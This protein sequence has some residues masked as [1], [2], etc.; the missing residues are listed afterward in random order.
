MSTIEATSTTVKV[1]A[2]LLARAVSNATLFA[3]KD[4]MRPVLTMAHLF[5]DNGK[6]CVETTDSYVAYRETVAETEAPEGFSVL[7]EVAELAPIVKA[8]KAFAAGMVSMETDGQSV[9]FDVYSSSFTVRDTTTLFDFPRTDTFFDQ[10]TVGTE[11]IAHIG[12]GAQ[13]L[14]RLA[15]VDPDGRKSAAKTGH[16]LKI[17]VQNELKPARVSWPMNDG[18]RAVVMPVRIS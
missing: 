6:V 11:P 17:E 18:I 15:K 3:S 14:A 9:R 7:V 13:V 10:F 4:R 5:A 2:D 8:C 16:A 1:R 12:F